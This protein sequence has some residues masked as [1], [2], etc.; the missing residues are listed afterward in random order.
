MVL[1]AL[2]RLIIDSCYKLQIIT[3]GKQ[4]ESNDILDKS[5][6]IDLSF[7]ITERPNSFDLLHSTTF[8]KQNWIIINSFNWRLIILL[9]DAVNKNS[10]F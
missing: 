1:F 3:W 6:V 5:Y 7:V 10:V 8:L 2:L 4:N 9:N